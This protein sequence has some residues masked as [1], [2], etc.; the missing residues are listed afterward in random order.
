MAILYIFYFMISILSCC[1]CLIIFTSCVNNT[2][3]KEIEHENYSSKNNIDLHNVHLQRMD[4]LYF[5]PYKND[6]KHFVEIISLDTIKLSTNR[7]NIVL[8]N[9]LQQIIYVG[10]SAFFEK[11]NGANWSRINFNKTSKSPI[12]IAN[13]VGYDLEPT[14]RVEINH[15]LFNNEYEYKTG[16]Y[17]ICFS[18][19][20]DG[21]KDKHKIY[22]NF[23]LILD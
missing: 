17:R 3:H 10:Q 14:E 22:K 9:R 5:F 13:A 23:Y 12:I 16:V 2:H 18:I 7:I 19:K 4:T 11:Q 8:V 6:N 1:I 20:I 15:L 21:E